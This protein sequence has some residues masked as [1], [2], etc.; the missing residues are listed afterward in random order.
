MVSGATDINMDHEYSRIMDSAMTLSY[1]LGP[2][3]IMIPVESLGH[4]NQ[5]G[6]SS[7]TA[8]RHQDSWHS[9]GRAFTWAL[10]TT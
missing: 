4:S 8:L 1:S 9:H 3:N 6:T 7:G 2:H 10:V 5:S